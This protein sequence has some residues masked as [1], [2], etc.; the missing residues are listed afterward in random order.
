MTKRKNCNEQKEDSPKEKME[1]VL[2]RLSSN[3][4]IAEVCQ[5]H[6]VNNLRLGI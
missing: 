2:S 6:G 3:G 1:I 5:R 4:G